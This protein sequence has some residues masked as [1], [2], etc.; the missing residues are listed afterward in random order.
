MATRASTIPAC[1][2]ALGLMACALAVP[3]GA[4]E[5]EA[6]APPWGA[7]FQQRL[8]AVTSPAREEDVQGLLE[9]PEARHPEG[10]RAAA[11]ALWHASGY[12]A[13]EGLTAL[14]THADAAVRQAALR[15]LLAL[16]LRVARLDAVRACLKD[17]DADVRQAAFDALARL[18]DGTDVEAMLDLLDTGTPTQRS[19]AHRVLVGLTRNPQPPQAGRWSAW[20]EREVPRLRTRLNEALALLDAEVE[21]ADEAPTP[22]QVEAAWVAVERHGWLEAAA[23]EA[24]ARAWL[25]HG[26][27]EV[28][29]QGH[30][31][32]LLR[33]LGHL[34]EEVRRALRKDQRS[35]AAEDARRA[36]EVLGVVEQDA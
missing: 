35:P 3:A 5:A 17:R 20:W 18:G 13:A 6:E 10:G 27:P 21:G 8:D 11:G 36:A 23:L 31:V 22:E 30:R 4:E 9:A 25:G 2:L 26:M 34:H 14:L 19:Q 15:G 28:R 29:R 33:R 1:L 7:A 32:V 12:A 16:D 24:R